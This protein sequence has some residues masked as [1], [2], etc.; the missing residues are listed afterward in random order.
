MTS[1]KSTN[2]KVTPTTWMS[3]LSQGG[4]VSL[5]NR[6]SAT[7]VAMSTME[8]FTRLLTTKMVPSRL[9]GPSVVLG[10]RMRSR[11]RCA[12]EDSSSS[13]SLSVWGDKLKNATSD[14]ETRAEITKST[15]TTTKLIQWSIKDVASGVTRGT[16]G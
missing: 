1:P 5:G 3:V 10:V 7:T 8:M 13:R 15:A 2:R 16:I 12:R 4:R 9:R 6:S 11:T 14:P